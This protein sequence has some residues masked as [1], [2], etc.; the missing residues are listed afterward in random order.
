[1]RR[2]TTE[3]NRHDYNSLSVTNDGQALL[4][5][6]YTRT[7]QIWSAKMNGQ[8]RYDAGNAV[9]LTTGISGGQ[10]GLVS[11]TD[12][13][14]VYVARTGDHVGLW[15]ISATGGQP[16]QLTT[17]R[18]FWRKWPRRAMVVSLSSPRIALGTAIFSAWIRTAQ[19]CGS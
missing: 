18:L 8:A 5:L 13:R 1:M 3:L 17:D 4:V 14:V 6:P 11:L 12:G 19:T 2:I 10:A 9:Q 16:K 15:Q 7:S